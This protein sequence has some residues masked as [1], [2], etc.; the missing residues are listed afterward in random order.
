MSEAVTRIWFSQRR[1]EVGIRMALGASPLDAL[2]LVL[3]DGGR[4]TLI[5][6]GLGI[7]I[8]LVMTRFMRS[9]L[10]DV[11]TMDPLTYAV[12]A[13]ALLG[14]GV[15]ASGIPAARAVRT[16]PVESLRAE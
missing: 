9:L 1:T 8:A 11:G 13:L 12:A 15:A 2:R 16:D 7:V 10:F 4:L 6:L 14:V 3:G 5:G